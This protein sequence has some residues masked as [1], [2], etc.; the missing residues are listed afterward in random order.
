MCRIKGKWKKKYGCKNIVISRITLIIKLFSLSRMKSEKI[1]LKI[2]IKKAW[3]WSLEQHT[4]ERK[5]KV[6]HNIS[7]EFN[8][9]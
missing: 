7:C 6:K 2:K 3:E 4:K 9:S 8:E 1:K 5:K